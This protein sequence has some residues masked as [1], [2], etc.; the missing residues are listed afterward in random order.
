METICNGWVVS[1]LVEHRNDVH[2]VSRRDQGL[3]YGG[4]AKGTKKRA[5]WEIL[6]SMIKL[7]DANGMKEHEGL[8]PMY[9]CSVATGLNAVGTMAKLV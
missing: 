9:G 6:T 7:P 2:F 1:Q 5:Q 4:D 8:G 3:Q